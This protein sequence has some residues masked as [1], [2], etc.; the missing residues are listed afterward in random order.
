MKLVQFEG[1][2]CKWPDFI[3]NFKACVHDKGSFTDNICMEQLLSMLSGEVKR[4]VFSVERNGISMSWLLILR[5]I[6]LELQISNIFEIK[7]RF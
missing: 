4:T 2:L 1:N 3:Q 7:N 5:K 6:N